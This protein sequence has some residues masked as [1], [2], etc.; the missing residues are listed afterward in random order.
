MHPP[1]ARKS[2]ENA[3]TPQQ[4]RVEAERCLQCFDAPCI[5]ACPA[6]IDIPSFIAMIRSGNLRGAAE[7]VKTSNPL[8]NVCGSVCPE[9]IY[10]QPACNRG[11]DDAPISIRELHAFVTEREA[12]LGYSPVLEPVRQE[13]QVAVVGGG[14][15]G[16]SCA[17][18][19]TRLGYRVT[20][21][22]DQRVGGV[23]GKSIPS[24]RLPQR[25][26][27]DDLKFLS[28]LFVLKKER[29]SASRLDD[30]RREYGAV[31]LGIGLG[32]D[33]RLLIKGER[34]K[35]VV[36]V[37][38]FLEAARSGRP[39]VGRHVIVV[40]GGNVS[41]D[42]AATA[43]RLGA[44]DVT[45]VYRRGER[46]MKV[47]KS[48]LREARA[49]GVGIRFLTN[50]VQIIGRSRVTGLKCRRML[51]SQKKDESGRQIP[52]EVRGSEVVLD[53]DM[54]IVAVGQV[55]RSDLAGRFALT[56]KGF[57]RVNR[58]FRTSVPG[59]FA[60]GDATSGEGTIVQSVAHGKAAARAIHEFMQRRPKRE[61]GEWM[62]LEGKAYDS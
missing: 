50:P 18:Q 39:R 3:F 10:C 20:I 8:A 1:N 14:P 44:R 5:Q 19:L 35:G 51:L 16:L 33:R 9:E 26:L 29:V 27:A 11:R 12:R 31:F 47:W 42:A 52:V 60:G 53:A 7:V 34:L 59:V 17:F 61:S 45:V 58:S 40:G 28:P 49:Q 32:E 36:P 15:A 62:P 2:K 46:E 22:D 4:A 30:L 48:E 23:P 24:F 37:L 55:I 13:G 43:M 6:R 25:V 57:I 38:R 54:V 56:G 21:L 41:L